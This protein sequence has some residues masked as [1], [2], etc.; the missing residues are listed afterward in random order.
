[1]DEAAVNSLSLEDLKSLTSI[2]TSD[3]LTKDIDYLLET[4]IGPGGFGQWLI[5]AAIIP[6]GFC[7]GFPLL[8]HMFAAYEPRHRCY[9]EACE[10]G[11]STT[12]FL[13]SWSNWAIPDNI[14]TKEMLKVEESY[15]SCSMYQPIGDGCDPESFNTSVTVPCEN[16]WIYE[17]IPFEE[18]LTTQVDLVCT[19]GETK[20]RLLSTIMMLGLMCGSL[21]GGRLGDKFGRRS[22]MLCAVTVVV[23]L[24]AFSGYAQDYTTYAVLRFIVCSA[25]PCIWVTNHSLTMEVFGSHYRKTAV[26]VKDF[27]WP[28]CQLLAV[29]I[30][31]A[32]RHWTYMHIW[33]G[34][35]AAVAW[36]CFFLIPESVRWLAVNG[37]PEQAEKILLQIAKRN[38][39]TV[40]EEQRLEIASVLQEVERDARE[41][42]NHEK[43]SPLDMFKKGNA[44]TTV[45]MVLNWVTVC[46]GSYTLLLNA[47][48]LYGDVFIN[49][50]L[51]TLAGDLPGT[52][53]LLVTL[54]Y[55]GRRFNLFYMQFTLGLCCLILAFIPKE[56]NVGI[57]IFYLIG[58][59]ASGAGFLLVWL[60]TA[61]LY[62]T[63][64]RAQAVGTCSTVA[65]IFGMVAPFVA[66]LAI[67]WKPLP[68]VVLGLPVLFSSFMV[69]F[70]PETRDVHL[71]TTM[72][73]ATQLGDKKNPNPDRPIIKKGSVIAS[74]AE[75][76]PK[77]SEPDVKRLES[78]LYVSTSEEEDEDVITEQTSILDKKSDSNNVV[79]RV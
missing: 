72:D 71:P 4:I 38:G 25:L 56:Y 8:I 7:S 52:L 74:V 3:V 35:A 78:T 26:L 58:K 64:L 36:P 13:P 14:N 22:V 61:E 32:N 48:K 20:R 53:A 33:S 6:V 54:K 79:G 24:L 27:I 70:L 50:I 23:P 41:K 43:L 9:V 46:V 75:V 69:Y 19:G 60:M 44:K 17:R 59:S 31:Y 34:V 15:D 57:I 68:M 66:Q 2:P 40:T 45:I 67:Y 73:E 11:N 18:T 28:S 29:L 30:Y 5:V 63:N 47:T 42:K 76:E 16:G 77:A 65:R 21:I 37:K 49:F 39:K 1:M 51:A 55:F 10:S 62:P 12:D